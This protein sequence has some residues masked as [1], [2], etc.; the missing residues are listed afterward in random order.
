MDDVISV[1]VGGSVVFGV[2]AA[3]GKTIS[4]ASMPQSMLLF[5]FACAQKMSYLLI[6]EWGN[7]GC[8][9][10]YHTICIALC[11]GSMVDKT[12]KKYIG[13]APKWGKGSTERGE[14]KKNAQNKSQRKI[15][16]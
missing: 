13:F 14:I 4:T 2:Q 3:R 1:S 9:Q 7:V 15:L 10:L 6:K 12:R 11:Q 5:M 16:Y 8:L